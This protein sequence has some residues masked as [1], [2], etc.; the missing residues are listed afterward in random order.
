MNFL[1]VL[2]LALLG[3]L[4]GLDVV[5]FPQAMISRPIVAS[6][7]AGTL[8][9]HSESGLLIGVVL[10]LI[11]LDTLPFG[12]S[13]YPEWGSAGVVGGALFAA[14]AHGMPGALPASILAALLTAS[15]SG[16]SMVVLRRTIAGRLERTRDQIEEGSRDA[17]VSLHLSGM[18]LDLLRAAL[19]TT[20]GML[21]F[22]PIVRA[23]VAIWGSESEYSRAV[24]VIVAAM[25]AG[26]ALWKVFHSVRHVIWFFVGGLVLSGALLSMS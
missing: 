15:I 12:A 9:G 18:T 10:E 24:V 19:V 16:S 17:L 3:G 22:S 26:G 25:V 20:L 2:P 7:L 21:V 1:E 23:I 11:A 4:L 14:Q 8:I 6:T 13:R 5:S